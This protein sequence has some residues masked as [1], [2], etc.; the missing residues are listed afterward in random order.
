M[1]RLE[2]G[3]PYFSSQCTGSGR[4]QQ[5]SY[6][7]IYDFGGLAGIVRSERPTYLTFSRYL[8]LCKRSST[9]TV[10]VIR[11]ATPSGRSLADNHIQLRRRVLVRLK[12]HYVYFCDRNVL[13]TY[14]KGATVDTSMISHHGSQTRQHHSRYDNGMII[15]LFSL[16][17]RPVHVPSIK[18]TLRSSSGSTKYSSKSPQAAASFHSASSISEF[19]SAPTH[20]SSA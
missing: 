6:Q 1:E 10:S 7:R 9:L 17:Q 19:S 20:Y 3:T 4:Q 15:L 11:L 18:L 16:F 2:E 13:K 12:W 5:V 14:F 8:P